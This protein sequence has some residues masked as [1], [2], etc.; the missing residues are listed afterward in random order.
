[1][2]C[3][4]FEVEIANKCNTINY[5]DKSFGQQRIVLLM[6]F[7][8]TN[9]KIIE[10]FQWRLHSFYIYSH[11]HPS[12]CDDADDAVLMNSFQRRKH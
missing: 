7:E 8:M 12:N 11:K 6:L 5:E 10:D 3:T 1:M 9:L 4:E 2:K